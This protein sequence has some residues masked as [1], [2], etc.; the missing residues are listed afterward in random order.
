MKA[1]QSN[2]KVSGKLARWAILLSE[3]NFTVIHKAGA[4]LHNADGLSRAAQEPDPE[5][6]RV[7]QV[8]GVGRGKGRQGAGRL[9][10]GEAGKKPGGKEGDREEWEAREGV[11]KGIRRTQVRGSQEEPTQQVLGGVT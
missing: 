7:L 9:G 10:S 4:T 1:L 6:E 5:D 11:G 2:N 3:F 8:W